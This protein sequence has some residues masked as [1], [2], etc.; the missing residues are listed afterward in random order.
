MQFDSEFDPVTLD[1]V[2]RGH[3]AHDT[4]REVFE[5]VPDGQVRHSVLPDTLA[6]EPE[7]QSRQTESDVAPFV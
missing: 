7:A 6:K 5:N 4:D 2:P 1:H 3:G